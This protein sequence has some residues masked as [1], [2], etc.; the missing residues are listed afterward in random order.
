MRYRASKHD[1][2]ACSMKPRCCPNTPARKIPRS[3]HEG[4]RD[5]AR[6]IATTDEYVTSR[7]QRKKVE[8]LFGHLKRILRL[9]RLRLRGPHGARD[10]FQLAA[11]A[12]NLRK[13][14]KLL[15]NGPLWM[16]A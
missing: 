12:Q 6:A 10:E 9:D 7:R 1:C 8:M 13:L 5:M 3:M 2:D 16:P 14:A 11:A 15:P 4:A